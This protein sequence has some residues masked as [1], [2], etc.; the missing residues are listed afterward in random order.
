MAPPTSDDIASGVSKMSLKNTPKSKAKKAEPVADSW[1]DE[2]V[3]SESEPEAKTE[4]KSERERE[5]GAEPESW[6]DDNNSDDEERAPSP[7]PSR[8]R[9][10]EPSTTTSV[11]PFLDFTGPSGASSTASSEYKRPEK[12]DAVARRMIA[13]ALGIKVKLSEEQKAYDRNLREKERKRK[14]E[15]RERK[16]KAEEEAL[17][18]KAA[19]W[20]D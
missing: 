13:G 9:K 14:E 2:D 8:S 1:E 17:K 7:P 3:S 12:T 11:P 16:K 4:Q 10:P 19:I 20:E 15:E 6:E 18:A 5:F